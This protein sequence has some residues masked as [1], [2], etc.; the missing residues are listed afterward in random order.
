EK[1]LAID[2]DNA[3]AHLGLCRLALRRR[4]FSV[5]AHAALDAL[6]R[7]HHYPLAHFLLGL[8]LAGMKEYEHAAAAFRAAISFNPNFPEAHVRLA[9]L[10]EKHLGD[11]E[12]AREHRRLA[13]RM[14]SRRASRPVSPFNSVPRR[15]GAETVESVAAVATP[16]ETLLMAQTSEM[17]PLDESLIVVTGLPRSGTSMLMQMLVAGG[18]GVLSDGRREA[19]QDNPRGYLEFEPVKRLLQDSKWLFQGRGKAIKIVAPLLVALPPGLACRVILSE[20]DL[21]ELLDSQERML[22][23]RN[24]SLAAKPERR[25]MLKNEYVNTLG[26]VKAILARRPGT[27]LLVIEHS[28]AISDP[29][30]TAE[31][32]NKFLGGGLNAAKMAAVIEPTL[33]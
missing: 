12:S 32:V 15:S 21:E 9:S 30:G 5:A 2:P 6:Q 8:A 4:K 17:P 25:R 14:R 16:R 22:V 10:L 31:K 11:A 18:M 20:R 28:N 27:Q 19:D 13:R 23:R 33:H 3:Q 26:R 1:A 29:I 7:I 24:Q